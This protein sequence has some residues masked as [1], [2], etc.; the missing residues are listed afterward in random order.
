MDLFMAQKNSHLGSSSAKM[1][2][3]QEARRN[4]N[5]VYFFVVRGGMPQVS[6]LAPVFWIL[7]FTPLSWAF[8]FNFFN[9]NLLT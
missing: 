4:R 3:D 6:P 7:V 1:W 8:D 9:F 5:N 2:I